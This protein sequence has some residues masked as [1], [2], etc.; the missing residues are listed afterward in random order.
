MKWVDYKLLEEERQRGKKDHN[1]NNNNN[2]RAAGE[3]WRNG[4]PEDWKYGQL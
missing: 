3:S 4:P 2:N 1:N